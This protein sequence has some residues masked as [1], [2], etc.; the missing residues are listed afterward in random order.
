MKTSAFA[1]V[2]FISEAKRVGRASSQ[3]IIQSGIILIFSMLE[4]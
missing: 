2:F 1:G 3:S 4:L